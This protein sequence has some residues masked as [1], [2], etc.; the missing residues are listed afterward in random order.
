MSHL[1]CL[2]RHTITGTLCASGRQFIDWS[3]DYR[4]YSKK[5]FCDYSLFQVIKD[6][7]DA[8]IKPQ[9]PLVVAMDDSLIR[10]R[11]RKI[12]GTKYQ[13]DP[14]SPPFNT[15]LV[16]SQR[17]VQ[18]SAAVPSEHSSATMIP[19]DF[20]HAPL[21][22]KPKR[23]ASKEEWESYEL[24]RQKANINLHGVG[25]LKQLRQSTD[26]DR[27]IVAVVD[28]RFTNSTILSNIPED[29]TLIGRV[30]GDAH[31]LVPTAER[32][33]KRGRPKLYD[34]KAP[35]PK[36]L[37]RDNSVPWTEVDAFAVGKMR[38]FKV[39]TISNVVWK[40]TGKS[41]K[42]NLIV[43]APVGYRLNKKSK[44][45][46]REPAFLICNDP[47]MPVAQVLQNYLWRW[48]IE[49]NF[50]DEKTLLGVGQAQVRN[51]PACQKAPALAVAAYAILLLASIKNN[52]N[53]DPAP[54][55]PVPKWRTYQNH[56]KPSTSQLINQLRADMWA[57]A[58]D[59][60]IFRDFSDSIRQN[61][62]PQKILSPLKSAAFFTIN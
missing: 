55:L 7:V 10:K 33:G 60:H 44:L 17:F 4:F 24:A 32:T 51:E 38:T 11:G 29:T 30:R 42:M 59:L 31:L 49:N 56:T 62:N 13:R 20:K 35:T 5:R 43:I 6:E 1:S 36:E 37:L 45:L 54:C 53:E 9:D 57:S 25:C 58:I 52:S 47:D 46:K 23:N 2:G 61:L 27:R 48:G 22:Q 21:P 16:L 18:L 40:A 19:I 15:N 34:Q 8:L 12:H 28:G 50:R 26:L 14:L 3:A 39:K 41:V